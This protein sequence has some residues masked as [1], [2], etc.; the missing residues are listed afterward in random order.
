MRRRLPNEDVHYAA[1]RL[2]GRIDVMVDGSPAI[3]HD[4][5]REFVRLV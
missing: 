4:H 1:D 5:E 3:V 2:Y